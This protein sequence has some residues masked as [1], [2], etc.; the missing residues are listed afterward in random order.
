MGFATRPRSVS[1]LVLALQAVSAPAEIALEG[2]VLI[3][4]NRRGARHATVL[5]RGER[6]AA[7]LPAGAPVPSGAEVV[8]L[9]GRTLIPGLSDAYWPVVDSPAHAALAQLLRRGVTSVRGV[10]PIATATALRHALDAGAAIGPRLLAAGEPIAIGTEAQ[11]REE[12]RRRVRQGATWALLGPWTPPDLLRAAVAEAGRDLPVAGPLW[13]TP[14]TIA[15]R[16]G[17]DVLLGPAPWSEYYLQP[18]DRERFRA[19]LSR[20]GETRAQIEWLAAVDIESA[21]MDRLV[22]W[23]HRRRVTVV[24]HLAALAER[25]RADRTGR[26]LWPKLLRL[27]RRFHDGGVLLAAGSGPGSPPTGR[28][29][30]ELLQLAAAGIAP[31]DLVG[32]A[33]RAGGATLEAGARADL[34]VLSASPLVDPAH[35]AD[36]EAVYLGGRAVGAPAPVREAGCD[37]RPD[38]RELTSRGP[39]SGPGTR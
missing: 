22:R 4:G 3:D 10:G 7:I 1:A 13:R 8:D 24:P 11:V 15:A 17:V 26:A 31:L 32:I 34:A 37:P 2:A 35:F 5:I 36:V 33:A 38:D 21:E 9:E 16:A 30:A 14:W 19:A 20:E 27:V 23:L 29:H 25:L 28:L 18:R 6:I 12:V 39:G